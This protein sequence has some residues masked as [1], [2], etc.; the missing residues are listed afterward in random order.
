MSH[1][2]VITAG[3]SSGIS[4]VE[5]SVNLVKNSANMIFR[6]HIKTENNKGLHF[7]VAISYGGKQDIIAATK[8]AADLVASGQITS[9][10]ITEELFESLLLTHEAVSAHGP[11]DLLIR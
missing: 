2:V 1:P 8:K 7:S 4:T 3:I 6:A 11:P 10:D 9:D 5:A